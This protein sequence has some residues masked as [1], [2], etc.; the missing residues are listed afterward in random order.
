LSRAFNTRILVATNYANKDYM[1][2]NYTLIVVYTIP[3]VTCRQSKK[4]LPGYGPIADWI[5][6][7]YALCTAIYWSNLGFSLKWCSLMGNLIRIL[8]KAAF[9]ESKG[10]AAQ[11]YKMVAPTGAVRFLSSQF[12][13]HIMDRTVNVRLRF[14]MVVTKYRRPITSN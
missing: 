2:V 12:W 3:L 13:C 8:K 1:H 9:M 14:H 6:Q 11:D 5:G 4:F 10:N 7:S